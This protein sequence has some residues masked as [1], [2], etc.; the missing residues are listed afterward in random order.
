[1]SCCCS[2]YVEIGCFNYCD[3][4]SLGYNAVQTG[5][6]VIEVRIS[7]DCIHTTSITYTALADM[8]IP[9]GTLNE[10]GP[11]DV[12]IKQPD[13][14]YYEFA[15]DITCARLVTQIHIIT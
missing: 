10:T 12:K 3:E 4:I 7:Q 13:G 8:T 15:T 11:K 1:M 9:A 5:V 6:H 14:S 2:E